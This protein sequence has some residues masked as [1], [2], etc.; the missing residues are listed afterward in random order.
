LQAP[1]ASVDRLCTTDLPTVA[2]AGRP[3]TDS[4]TVHRRRSVPRSHDEMMMT[5]TCT[6]N[7]M[8]F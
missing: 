1:A 3:P 2:I 6:V 5:L 8:D 7:E 4:V